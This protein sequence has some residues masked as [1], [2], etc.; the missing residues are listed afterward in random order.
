MGS[1]LGLGCVRL[2]GSGTV[3]LRLPVVPL[4]PLL[5]LA[6]SACEACAD[7]CSCFCSCCC[8]SC[9]S[10]QQVVHVLHTELHWAFLCNP[11]FKKLVFVYI[12]KFL[13]CRWQEWPAKCPHTAHRVALVLALVTLWSLHIAH[14]YFCSFVTELVSVHDM[15]PLA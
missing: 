11:S 6:A 15:R 5:N 8:T 9:K 2:K 13:A 3:C 4:P 7:S 14:V 10:G 12:M 1:S